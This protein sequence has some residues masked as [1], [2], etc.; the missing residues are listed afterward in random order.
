MMLILDKMI[1]IPFVTW[2]SLIWDMILCNGRRNAAGTE[3]ACTFAK[4]GLFRKRG[5]AGE[6]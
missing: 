3:E 4:A 5:I 2:E 6:L 1:D